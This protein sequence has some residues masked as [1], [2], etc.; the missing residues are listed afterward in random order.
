M[1]T[2]TSQ[3][4]DQSSVEAK[5]EENPSSSF[6]SV[7]NL[8]VRFSFAC[9][10]PIYFDVLHNKAVITPVISILSTSNSEFCS[11]LTKS[12][13][14]DEWQENLIECKLLER[15]FTCSDVKSTM[16]LYDRD[17]RSGRTLPSGR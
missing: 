6:V 13:S 1:N 9:S 11:R 8:V 16:Q 12:T 14:K 5:I 17:R 4:I 15:A 3:Q 2:T 7:Y 10:S